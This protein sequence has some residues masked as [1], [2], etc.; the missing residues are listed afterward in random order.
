MARHPGIFPTFFL[1]GFECSNFLWKDGKRRNLVAETGHD[2]HAAEDYRILNT[3]GIAVS[4]E[5]IPWPLVTQRPP[6]LLPRR[7][8]SWEALFEDAAVEVRDDLAARG[9]LPERTWG[10]HNTAAICHPLAAAV[11]LLGKR[12]LCM[13]AEPLPGD[14]MMARV[15]GPAFGASQRMVVAPGHEVDGIIHMPGGQSGHPLSPF[16]GAGHA[17]WVAGRAT[18]FLPGAERNRLT[19]TPGRWPGP[20]AP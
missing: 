3:L 15:Q 13:P 18:P 17:D 19:L 2:R 20:H 9:P 6:H 10:E 7:F 8:D 1:S 11:P 16:W 14:G 5:G 12:W 4:R